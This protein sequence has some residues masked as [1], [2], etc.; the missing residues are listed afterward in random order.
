[1]ASDSFVFDHHCIRKYP[2][3]A[4]NAVPEILVAWGKAKVEAL[5][6]IFFMPST[7]QT[8]STLYEHE[9]LVIWN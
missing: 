6:Q 5:R 1:M 7:N 3:V 9:P 4:A 2:P 8:F